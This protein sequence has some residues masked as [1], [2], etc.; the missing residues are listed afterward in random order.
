VVLIVKQPSSS[1]RIVTKPGDGRA[2]GA[3]KT[4]DSASGISKDK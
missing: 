3:P 4:K 2:L 1:I